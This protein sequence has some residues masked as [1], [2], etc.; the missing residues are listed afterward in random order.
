MDCINHLSV[1]LWQ[2]IPAYILSVLVTLAKLCGTVPKDNNHPL[3][4][5]RFFG[6]YKTHIWWSIFM[7]WQAIGKFKI[8]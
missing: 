5:F 7:P 8:I 6:I 4:T 1:L 2:L 3:L